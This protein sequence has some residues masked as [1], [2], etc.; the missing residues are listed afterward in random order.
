MPDVITY[1]TLF[2]G[3]HKN[4]HHD[5]AMALLRKM[6]NNGVAANIVICNSQLDRLCESGR[7][8]DAK[9]FFSDLLSKGL[10]PNCILYSAMIKGLCRKG[11][12][13]EATELL[14]KM[15]ANVCFPDSR[16]YN[17]IMRGFIRNGE[18][19]NALYYRD[20]MVN[21]GFGAEAETMSLLMD[22]LSSDQL[23]VSSKELLQKSSFISDKILLD[24]RQFV[25]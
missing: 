14:R 15:E 21:N 24:H 6:H 18:L 12:L 7:V 22:L 25:L 13:S 5:E 20:I 11:L 19:Q 3:L 1:G 17:T 2:D 8:K 16:N 10:K 23:S 4:G 9:D